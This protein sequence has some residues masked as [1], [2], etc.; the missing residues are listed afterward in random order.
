MTAPAPSAAAPR[1]TE[2]SGRRLAARAPARRDAVRAEAAGYPVLIVAG[3]NNSGP[4]HWQSHW[5]RALPAAERVEQADWG[6]PDLDAWLQRLALA[7]ERRPGALLVAHSLGCIL[8]AHLALRPQ[9]LQVAGALLVAPADVDTH[10]PAGRL[11]ESS[12]PAPRRRLPFPTTVVASRNDPYMSYP[13]ATRLAQDWGGTLVDLGAAGH[14]NVES[15]HG[16]WPEGL[17]LL[18]QLARRTASP[19]LS[20]LHEL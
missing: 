12:G 10:G 6:R 9:A 20:P 7:V 16:P 13:T 17:A 3:L 11:V 15:G 14:V 5:Q 2:L 4:G 19:A 18:G 8:A 1:P